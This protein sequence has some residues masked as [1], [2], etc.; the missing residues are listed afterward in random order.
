MIYRGGRNYRV[1]K[2]FGHRRT[3]VKLLDIFKG[4]ITCPVAPLVTRTFIPT[5]E[6]FRGRRNSN[7]EAN[8]QAVVGRPLEE[9]GVL[10]EPLI[11]LQ[12]GG[13]FVQGVSLAEIEVP[14]KVEAVLI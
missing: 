4:I 2:Q 5:I 3:P 1:S 7:P 14:L 13:V 11:L 8:S 10:I 6:A 12:V 9:L